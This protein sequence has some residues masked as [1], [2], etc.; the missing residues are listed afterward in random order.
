MNQQLKGF[1]IFETGMIPSFRAFCFMGGTTY[2]LLD[3]P[4]IPEL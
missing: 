4:T 2:Q 3:N 1:I